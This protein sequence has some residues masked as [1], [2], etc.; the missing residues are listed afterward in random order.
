M[1][2][3]LLRDVD[4]G[5]AAVWIDPRVFDLLAAVQGAMSAV[6]GAVVPLI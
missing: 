5:D 1:L 4:D 2:S 3:W 6:H